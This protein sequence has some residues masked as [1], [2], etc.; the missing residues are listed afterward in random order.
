MAESRP[1]PS[2]YCCYLLRST[3]R[4]ASL[5]VGSTPNPARRLAQH[6][7]LIKGGAV[8]TSRLTLRPW[9]MACIVSGFPSQVA[10][11]Q[12]EW[13][14]QNTHLTR[15]IPVPQRITEARTLLRVSPRSGKTRRRPARP[16][17]SLTDKLSNLHLLLRADTFARWP[18]DVRFFCQDVFRVWQRWTERVDAPVRDGIRVQLDTKLPPQTSDIPDDEGRAV[19]V[20]ATARGNKAAAIGRGGIDG[21]DV[22]FVGLKPHLEKSKA[23]LRPASAQPCAVCHERVDDGSAL[24]ATCPHPGCQAV[25]HLNC[26]SSRFMAGEPGDAVIPTE[27]FCPACLAELRWIDVVKELSLRAFGPKEVEKLF[28]KPREKKTK[29]PRAKASSIVASED[30]ESEDQEPSLDDTDDR[31]VVLR[32]VGTILTS[33]EPIP[34]WTYRDDDDLDEVMSVMT[35][36]SSSSHVSRLG[37]SHREPGERKE[38]VIEDS[39]WDD[40]E[41]LD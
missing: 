35:F 40:V 7:G 33:T 34:T 27:G 2:F 29:H 26:L 25:S 9:E 24:A 23:L 39:D 15:H 6:N 38:A 17:V 1:I 37:G 20:Q 8:K 31:D 21:L 16:R 3:V 11:L 36:S 18:L 28:K 14:W 10:A 4:H 22:G 19:T 41:I 30:E 12:F 32:P 5:Y 13:A